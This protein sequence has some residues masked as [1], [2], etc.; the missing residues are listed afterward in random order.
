[1]RSNQLSY[2]SVPNENY[3]ITHFQNVNTFFNYFFW[4]PKKKKSNGVMSIDD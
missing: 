4:Y 1:M 3:Y 2:A